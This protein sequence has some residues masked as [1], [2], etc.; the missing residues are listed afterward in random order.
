[1]AIEQNGT[2]SPSERIVS[3]GVFTRE[4]DQSFLAQGVAAIGGVVVAPFPK[5]PG[6]SPTVVT[7]E[8]DLENIFG[9]ADGTLYGPV[10]AQQY[11]RQQGQVTVVR[12]GG[13]AGYTQEHPIIIS[14]LPGTYGRYGDMFTFTGSLLNATVNPN[15]D[16][17]GVFVISGSLTATV[18]GG[19]YNGETIDFGQFYLNTSG[20]LAGSGGSGSVVGTFG[21]ASIGVVDGDTG[22]FLSFTSSIYN[23]TASNVSFTGSAS[24]WGAARLFNYKIARIQGACGFELTIQGTITGSVGPFNPAVFTPSSVS[25]EDDCGSASMVAGRD[26]V[27]LAVLANTA[28]DRGQNLYGFSGSLL[29]TSSYKFGTTNSTYINGNYILTLNEAHADANN[30]ILS[31]SYGSYE[32]S[33]NEDSPRYITNVFGADAKAG[34]YPVA[35][36]QKLEAAYLYKI[37]K[38]RIKNVYEEMIA[39]GSWK[40][41]VTTKN[42]AMV[43]SDGIEP[44]DGTSTFDLTNAY[45]PFIRSQ[46]TALFTSAVSGSTSSSVAYDLFKVH[47]LTDGTSANTAYKIEISNVKSAGSIPGSA[48][49]S[50]T[51]AVRSYS[52]TDAKPVYL[53]RFDNLN[54]DVNSANYV[55]RRI[56]DTYNYIDFNGKILEFGDFPQKSKYVR[57]EMATSP[58]PVEAIPFG[59]GPYA[60]PIGGD[61]ARLNKVP[62][63]AYTSASIYSLQPGRYASGVVFQPAPAQADDELAA[64][65]PSGSTVGPELDNKQYFSAIPQGS[66]TGANVAF[67]LETVCGVSP[68][69]VAAQEVT[70][71]KK[72]KFILGFQGGFDGQSPSV[73]LLIGNDILPTNQ[74]GLDCSTNV[75]RGTYAYKQAVAALSN[76]D[77]FDFNL[78]TTPGINYNYHPAVAT[79]VVDMCE[80]RGDAFYIMDIA[81]NQT[82]GASAIQNVVDLAGQFDTNYAATYYPWVKVTETNSNKIMPVPPSVVMMSVYAANDKVSAEWFAP[83]GLNRGGIPTAVSVADRLTHTERDTLYEGHVNPIAAF[84]GQGVVAWGQKTLQRNPSALDRVN[85]RRLLIALKKFI[86]SSSRFLVFEQNVATTRQ[87]FLNIVNPYLESVQQRSGVYAFK[88]VMDDSNNTPDLVD[89]GILYGQIYI[90]PTRTAEMIVLD[91]NVLPTGAAF[92]G[93]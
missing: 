69:F 44:A 64:L 19:F 50:F 60:T 75:K 86:A 84:P 82:A 72:R 63:M 8:G 80:R 9:A 41:S 16:A 92:P 87:R 54:L 66:D 58:W 35:T 38:H 31:S 73:P 36:G 22:C 48:Y 25:A 18:D 91:F 20:S 65:Y 68:L 13:L 53:E 40:I 28:L 45:T 49:G 6:F 90:Q 3:P 33:I 43:F 14:A 42:T 30:N 85:V 21:T 2:Y 5:G 77:E 83:A 34:Y 71:S 23:N 74:Q 93:A 15:T 26:E 7:S 17:N 11:L 57:I 37:F 55:A 56:G 32:F 52:D 4:I 79:A 59:F 27:V 76:A 12:V 51:L 67:D 61:F 46:K 89:R 39:S 81:P 24:P 47:T 29:T 62:A 88:V 10:T 78:I 70:N 1:M